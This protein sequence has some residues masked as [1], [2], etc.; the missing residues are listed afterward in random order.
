MLPVSASAVPC[1]GLR[2]FV[3]KGS[4]WSPERDRLELPEPDQ[5]INPGVIETLLVE[6][7]GAAQDQ[8]A[9]QQILDKAYD[10][11]TLKNLKACELKDE[12]VLGL[13]LRDIATLL[14]CD[15]EK[16]PELEKMLFSTALRIKEKIYGNRIVLFAPMYTSN[17]CAN[18]CL[19][20]GF[21]GAN[22]ELHRVALTDAQVAEEA[23]TMIRNGHKRALMLCGEH[24]KYTLDKFVHH[25]NV[26]GDARVR[27]GPKAIENEI[28]RINVEIPPLSGSDIRKLKQGTDKVGTFTV[29]QESYHYPSYR[30]FHQSGP[31]SDFANRLTAHHRALHGGIDDYGMGVLYGLYDYKYETL[32]LIMHAMHMNDTR[33]VGPHTLSVPRIKPALNAPV[34]QNVPFPVNDSEFKKIVAVLRLAVPYTGMI[35]STRESRELRNELLQLGIS[36][37]SAGSATEPGGYSRDDKDSSAQFELADHRTVSEV[38]EDLIDSGFVPSQCT[39]CYKFGRTGEVFMDW[40]KSGNI[41]NYCL[42]NALITLNEYAEDYGDQ[43]VRKKTAD[44]TQRSLR[45][46]DD[47]DRVSETLSRIDRV[48][49]GE[50][51]YSLLF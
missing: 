50:R 43:S 34:A 14:N 20:C 1:T 9:V 19:Y 38:V 13:S 25:V 31:K 37:L 23:R 48:K 44:V 16:N 26:V 5:V 27:L 35:L 33:G 24:P 6:T 47:K 28:R 10:N 12:F 32:G 22:A 7:K 40:A 46:L 49:Q 39:S 4:W 3:S 45:S 8:A 15:F 36:Q 17:Y 29:F 2:T 21:R 51:G 41:G 18:S 42:P 11:A 30:K